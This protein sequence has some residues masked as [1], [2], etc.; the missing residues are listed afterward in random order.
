MWFVLAEP[1]APV[2]VLYIIM[3]VMCS[4]INKSTSVLAIN[5]YSGGDVFFRQQKYYYVILRWSTSVCVMLEVMCSFRTRS[6]SV[7]GVLHI[8]EVTCT[9]RTR[10][11]SVC[12]IKQG[13]HSLWR[14]LKFRENG[15]SFSRPWKSVKTE[16]GLWK[17]VNLWSSEKG[18][19]CQLSSQKLHF[20]RLNSS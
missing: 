1:E 12:V 2:Y 18:K 9:F 5:L 16:W 14:S 4:F 6:T 11:I 13:S 20:P 7:C 15:I 8:M 3:E 17:F 10:S 19:N